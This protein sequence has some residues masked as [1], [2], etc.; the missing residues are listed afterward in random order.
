MYIYIILCTFV[1]KSIN[2]YN[3]ISYKWKYVQGVEIFCPNYGLYTNI[4]ILY[5][6]CGKRILWLYNACRRFECR[7]FL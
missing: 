4:K 6:H 7:E 1:D 3:N 5:V 2:Y